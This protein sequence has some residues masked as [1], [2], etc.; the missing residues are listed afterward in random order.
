MIR[1]GLSAPATLIFS[2]MRNP[3]QILSGYLWWTYERGSIQYDVMVTFILLFLFLAPYKIDFK[4]RPAAP[5]LHRGQIIIFPDGN[6][7]VIYEVP[8]AILPANLEGGNA[9]GAAI[10]RAITPVAGPVTLLRY[11]PVTD[12]HGKLVSYRAWVSR[13][14]VISR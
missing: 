1:R 6:G 10:V 9:I 4:D 11:E 14:P 7:G 12:S 3:F 13:Q 5:L 2:R 8:V